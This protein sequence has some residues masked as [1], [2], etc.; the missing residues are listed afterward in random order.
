MDIDSFFEK[1]RKIKHNLGMKDIPEH[2]S[3]WR[4]DDTICL[5]FFNW[6]RLESNA[7][8]IKLN[9]NSDVSEV[10]EE[11]TARQ[12]LGVLHRS[13]NSKGW[14]SIV[15]H[16]LSS[17]MTGPVHDYKG[18]VDEG[19]LESWT[20]V[21]RF[22]PKTV[23]WIKKTIPFNDFSRIRVMMLDPN[24][25]INPHKDMDIDFLG[26]GLNIAITNPKGV[27]FA[28]DNSG[29]IPW[30]IGDIR[31]INI[32]KYHSVI[33]NS[34]NLRIHILAYPRTIEWDI[35]SMQIVCE[36]YEQELTNVE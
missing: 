20:D 18:I 15:L 10:A 8:S 22:F 12:H 25:Y 5:D 1:N 33:N 11:L 23:S 21:S 19:T 13:S 14:R 3:N 36:S 26:G 34:E 31:M 35:K 28:I 16:G 32:G 9:I 6:I 27:E 30:N 4:K 17:I 29:I 2:F 7:G 24:G